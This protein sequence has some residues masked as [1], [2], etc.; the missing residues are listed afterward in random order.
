MALHT[1]LG[2][3]GAIG[4]ALAP[5]LQAENV[6]TRLVSRAPR[7][8]DWME[9]VAADL[10]D[11]DATRKAV[12]GSTVV[13]LLAGLVYDV[14][15]WQVQ[16]PKIMSNV[17]AACKESSTRL[18]F[19]DNVYMYG[20]V[21]GPMT[22]E[23]QF[24][25][26][27]EK[28]KVRAQIAEQLLAEMRSSKIT[29]LIARSADFYGPGGAKSS[30][31]NLMVFANLAKGKK[32]QWLCNADVPHSFTYIPDAAQALYLLSQRDEA[33]G[34]TWH[35]PTASNPLTGRQFVATAA[36]AMKGPTGL[37]LVPSWMMSVGGLFNRTFKEAREMA[38]QNESPYLFDSSKFDKAFGFEP[39]SYDQGIL[40]TADSFSKS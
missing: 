2:A 40:R 22:E 26:A 8:S 16:W 14:R 35:L 34:Q 39:V 33:F 20:R 15:I 29:A 11:L 24:K 36:T 4:N 17:I 27:S 21:D 31:P 23:T 37:S 19:F 12:A 1:F 18:I 25:P 10:T 6:P 38:Y 7:A 9:A 30:V 13:Y 3:G 5:I 32:S 28:G